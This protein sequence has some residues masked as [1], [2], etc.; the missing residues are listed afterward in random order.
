LERQSYILSDEYEEAV[1]PMVNEE[2]DMDRDDENDLQILNLAHSVSG[3]IL[4]FLHILAAEN[5]Y[6]VTTGTGY[7]CEDDDDGDDYVNGV[8]LHL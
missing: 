8:R 3:H 7:Y 5:F 1:S 6:S 2:L 4:N